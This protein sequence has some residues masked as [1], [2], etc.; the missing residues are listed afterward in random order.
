MTPRERESYERWKVG[1]NE[2]RRTEEGRAKERARHHTRP[3]RAGQQRSE[4]DKAQ[5]A[6][7]QRWFRVHKLYMAVCDQLGVPAVHAALTTLSPDAMMRA[8]G[9]TDTD[10]GDYDG[11][12]ARTDGAPAA[13]DRAHEQGAARDRQ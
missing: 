11:A 8:Q 5:R 7:Y 4:E 10:Q 3:S 2:R 9:T 6:E 1:Q 13:P 12:E